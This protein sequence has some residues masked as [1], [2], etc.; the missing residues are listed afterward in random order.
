MNDNSKYLQER[1]AEHGFDTENNR[2]IQ[3]S[4]SHT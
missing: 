4:H 2:K 3:I 1:E